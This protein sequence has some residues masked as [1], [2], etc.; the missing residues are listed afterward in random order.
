MTAMQISKPGGDF[1]LVQKEIPEPGKN[2]VRIKVQACGI[3]HGDAV[4]KEGH[5]PGIKYPRVP[6]H[7]VVGIIDK[8]GKDIYG[9]K[10]GQRVGVGWYGGPCMKCETC[11]RGD[12]DNC[13]SSLTTGISFDGGYEEY[14]VA[15]RQ[16]LVLIPEEFE[17]L[18][19]APLLCAGRTTY[20]ALRDSGAKGGDV[21]AIQGIGGLGHLAVQFSRKLGFKT[22][23]LSRGNGKKKLALKLGAHV[24][25]D[26]EAAD[27]VKELQ[28]LG[29]AKV[30]LAT[31]PNGKA[32]SGLVGGLGYD[33][34]LLIVSAPAE[35]L[36][37]FA[38]QLFG[39]RKSIRGW[40]AGGSD[41]PADDALYF[42]QLT[43]VLPVIE[44]FPLE[45]AAAAFEKMM[46][47]RVHFRSVLKISD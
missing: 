1:E 42:S 24:Y 25:I 6:G 37:I 38:G 19:A 8:L 33:G 31:A 36:Q 30:I 46:T 35:P 4:V 15:A 47:A 28:K 39:G 17:S 43:G 14:M 9:W 34:Q 29:G 13:R 12:L 40:V 41:S 32:I 44:V 26:T 3:C 22:V 27:P 45:Q 10:A 16:A 23:A 21:V 7:E 18:E 20:T 2:E 11:R 5:Y